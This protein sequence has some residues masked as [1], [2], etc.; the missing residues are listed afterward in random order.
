MIY[1]ILCCLSHLLSWGSRFS[2]GATGVLQ[3]HNDIYRN[4]FH[5]SQFLASVMLRIETDW[6]N[7]CGFSR[8]P[9]GEAQPSDCPQ[10]D[11]GGGC[12][13]RRTVWGDLKVLCILYISRNSFCVFYVQSLPAPYQKT[14][15]ILTCYFLAL[16]EHALWTEPEQS[17][18]KA[19]QKCRK[20][21]LYMTQSLFTQNRSEYKG[22]VKV[23]IHSKNPLTS[24]LLTKMDLW[25]NQWFKA[26]TAHKA[27]V[28]NKRW[29]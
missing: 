28:I 5:S 4:N 7:V 24:K 23:K 1:I 10:S 16:H 19:W 27:H 25:S 22:D 17:R 18:M 11:P 21:L 14:G 20:S 2:S 8:G 9:H 15:K 29:G 6:L 12:T 13:W 3:S 26:L